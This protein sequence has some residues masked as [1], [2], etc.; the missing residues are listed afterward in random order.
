MN[1]YP[2]WKYL[3]LITVIVAGVI[4]AL[5][6]IYGD[7]PAVQITPRD[8]VLGKSTEDS[9]D[10]ALTQ[11]DI[12]PVRIESGDGKLLVRFATI[13][14]QLKA[15]NPL[16]KVLGDRHIVALNLAPAT[17]PW[18]RGFARP[19]FLGLDL[20]GGV[21][22]LMQVDMPAAIK[23]AEERFTDDIRTF[24]RER[25]IRYGGVR[26]ANQQL[27][28]RFKTVTLRDSTLGELQGGYSDLLFSTRDRDGTFFI[29][30]NL[31]EA[32]EERERTATLQQ[33]VITLRNRVNELGVAEPVVQRQGADRIVV[34]LPG[35]QDT[36]RAKEI[37]GATATLEYRMVYG[38]ATDWYAAEESGRVPA[39][40]RLYHRR[41]DS[42]PI[43][44]QRRVIVTG[45]QIEDAA[46][47]ID[48]QSGSPA[49]FVNLD[50]KGAK[51]MQKVSSE[52][53]GK[54]MAVVFIEN[55]VDN[56]EID[57]EIVK[58]KRRVEEVINAATIRD[59]LSHRFQTTGLDSTEARNLALLLR[60]GALKG[61]DRDY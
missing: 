60:A 50:G 23:Q 3:I 45:D 51:R 21:H 30:A 41:D 49:V 54:L 58:V 29:E 22:F 24:M 33:N 1:R 11:I 8:G 6:N 52:N 55:R 31:T 61:A 5:P 17:P 38:T 2:V 10:A 37:L 4:Y 18:L 40:A 32:A 12:R 44:L 35:I 48:Q 25:K 56:R 13:D 14:D 39:N 57:G 7:D 28:I 59:V 9:I 47:G 42:S 34:Q 46:A 19:M 43:L 53:I 16:I 15:L 20:R 26:Y 36:G 27:E